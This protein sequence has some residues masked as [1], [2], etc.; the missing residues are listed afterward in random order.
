MRTLERKPREWVTVAGNELTGHVVRFLMRPATEFEYNLAV[1]RAGVAARQLA[2]AEEAR[3]IYGLDELPPDVF[4]D[5]DG[6]PIIGVSTT[7]VATELAMLI[8]CDVEGYVD[9]AGEKYEFNRRNVGMIMMDWVGPSS[10]ARQF[11]EKALA[12]VY[13]VFL[14]GKPSAAALSG[15]GAAAAD[16]AK[17]AAMPATPAPEGS[18]GKTANSARPSKTPR[19]PPKG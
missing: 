12:G 4:G 16:I 10:V 2:T 8:A 13:R 7:L 11:Q 18:R 3:R 5:A 6:D 17:D 14:E 19:K 1:E 9:G 15:I